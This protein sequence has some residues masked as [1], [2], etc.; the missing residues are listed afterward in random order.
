MK[1]CTTLFLIIFLF[2]TGKSQDVTCDQLVYFAGGGKGGYALKETKLNGVEIRT[3]NV[4]LSYLLI[5]L[6]L[7]NKST[8][9]EKG[10]PV[11]F[12]LS[13]DTQIQLPNDNEVT[14]ST[15]GHINLGGQ[16]KHNEE[17]QQLKNKKIRAIQI[18]TK[19]GS[20]NVDLTEAEQARLHQVLNCLSEKLQ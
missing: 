3:I 6:S 13:D 8:C 20:M 17:L 7:T 10:Q 1:T 5:S 9:F 4:R 11:T 14:S 2:N 15:E 18:P 19:S 12:I 16:H